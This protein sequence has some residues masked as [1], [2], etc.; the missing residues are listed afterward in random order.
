MNTK[1]LLNR[2]VVDMDKMNVDF[3]VEAQECNK[4]M[5][6]VE[7]PSNHVFGDSSPIFEEVFR[8][9]VIPRNEWDAMYDEIRPNYSRMKT[10]QYNQRNEGTCTANAMGGTMSYAYNR[11]FGLSVAPCPTTMYRHCGRSANSGSST[12]CIL[13]RARD[14]GTLLIDHEQSKDLLRQ[15]KLD[16]THVAPATGWNA[17]IPRGSMEETAIHFRIDEFYEISTIDGFFSALLHGFG[18][19][20][21][22]S[23]HAIHGV[24]IVKRSGKWT[25]KYDNSWGNWGD[26]GFGYDSIDYLKRT[27]ASRYGAFAVQTMVSPKGLGDVINAPVPQV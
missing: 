20:Y 22:R 5:G 9:K 11:Q 17:H 2:R 8:E 15:L 19:L 14:H 25:C 12:V 27:N 7:L 16:P 21:G 4:G 13:K 10:W 3:E 24:D 26:N 6:L 1:N 18:I 23:G